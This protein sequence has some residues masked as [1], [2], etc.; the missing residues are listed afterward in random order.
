MPLPLWKIHAVQQKISQMKEGPQRLW[1]LF[2]FSFLFLDCLFS[3]RLEASR[4]S[5]H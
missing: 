1:A 3:Q 4:G 5:V 2:I